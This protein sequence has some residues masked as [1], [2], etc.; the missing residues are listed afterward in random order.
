M[1]KRGRGRAHPMDFLLFADARGRPVDPVAG[2]LQP[3][4]YLLIT[5]G[6][7]A[8]PELE[9]S[10]FLVVGFVPRSGTFFGS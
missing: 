5:T 3:G 1:V 9:G 8:E 2:I 10:P 4:T 6:T 7:L